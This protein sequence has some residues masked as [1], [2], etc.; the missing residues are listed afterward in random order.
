MLIRTALIE[1]IERSAL[2]CIGHTGFCVARELCVYL[3]LR[4]V[5]RD[6][7]GG[8]LAEDRTVYHMC[9]DISCERCAVQMRVVDAEIP[10]VAAAADEGLYL[11]LPINEMNAIHLILD[12]CN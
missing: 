11:S 3:S 6:L 4:H 7:A 10:L 1:N 8:Q 12:V 5:I 2:R 9:S